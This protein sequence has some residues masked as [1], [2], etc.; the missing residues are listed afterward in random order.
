[1]NLKKLLFSS[2]LIFII[3]SLCHFLYSTFPCFLTSIFA[4]V[5]ESIFEH[6]KMLFTAEMIFSI[7]TFLKEKEDRNKYLRMLLRGYLSIFILLL[8]YL[9]IYSFFGEHMII[10]LII[11]WITVLLTEYILTFLSKKKSHPYLNIASIFIIILTYVLF[12]YLTY[13]PIK[14]ALFFDTKNQKY[15]IDILNK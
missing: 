12:T 10:T 4:P 13:H 14:E 9:P 8:L 6:L 5:N 3:S 1:M 2:I 7:G 15:G 11:L